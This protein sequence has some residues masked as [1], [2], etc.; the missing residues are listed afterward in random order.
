MG[1]CSCYK[2]AG[3]PLETA[4][5]WCSGCAVVVDGMLLKLFVSFSA[6]R[7]AGNGWGSGP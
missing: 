5:F 1:V 4:Y 2:H 6:K 7:F 3:E